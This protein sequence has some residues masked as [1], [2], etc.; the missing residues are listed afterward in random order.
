MEIPDLSGGLGAVLGEVCIRIALEWKWND[1]LA[2][3]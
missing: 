3:A 1:K 2:Q